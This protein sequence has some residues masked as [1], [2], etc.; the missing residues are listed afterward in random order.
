MEWKALGLHQDPVEEAKLDCLAIEIIEQ[1]KIVSVW[2]A[3]LELNLKKEKEAIQ[4]LAAM[5]RQIREDNAMAAENNKK[6][7]DQK[8]KYGGIMN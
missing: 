7:K 6:L 2:Q 3:L 8:E 5:I 1:K 4:T